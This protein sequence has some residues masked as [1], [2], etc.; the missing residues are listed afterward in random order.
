MAILSVFFSIF[1]LGVVVII[2]VVVE[3]PQALMNAVFFHL[4]IHVFFFSI[5]TTFFRLKLGVLKF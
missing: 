3:E 1:D 4:K 5:R 2:I